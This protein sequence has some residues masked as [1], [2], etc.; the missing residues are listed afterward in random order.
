MHKCKTSSE[1]D[2]CIGILIAFCVYNIWADNY[3]L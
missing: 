1:S 3:T 2:I